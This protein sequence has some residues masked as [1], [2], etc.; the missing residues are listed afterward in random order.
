MCQIAK[1]LSNVVANVYDGETYAITYPFGPYVH[2]G[3]GADVKHGYNPGNSTCYYDTTVPAYRPDWC[4]GYWGFSEVRCDEHYSITALS[5]YGNSWTTTAKIPTALGVLTNL[6]EITLDTMGLTGP[7]PSQL[8][9]L[10]R[11]TTLSLHNN[12]LTGSVPAFVANVSSWSRVSLNNNCN[13]TSSIPAISNQMTFSSQGSCRND[14]EVIAAEGQAICKIARAWSNVRISQWNGN[15]YVPKPVFSNNYGG[16]TTQR[17]GYNPANSTCY[18]NTSMP[19]HQPVWCSFWSG[20]SCSNNKVTSLSI[21]GNSWTN[22][23]KVPTAIGALT[24]L[25]MLSLYNMGLTGSIPNL[26]GLSRLSTLQLVRNMLTGVVPKF[27]NY[28]ANNN[29]IQLDSNCNLTSPN[30]RIAVRLTNNQGGQYCKPDIAAIAAEGQAMCAVAQAWSN[31]Q[32]SR[33]TGHNFT[34][35][36]VFGSFD[37]ASTG[38]KRTGYIP[39]KTTCNYYTNGTHNSPSSYQPTWCSWIGV[40]CSNNR[41]SQLNPPTISWTKTSKIPTALGALGNLQYLRFINAG[42]S[43]S[44]PNL[45]GLSKLQSLYLWGNRLTGDVPAFINTMTT[46]PN[47]YIDLEPNCN[48]TWTSTSPMGANSNAYYQ[49]Q[50]NCAPLVPLKPGQLHPLCRL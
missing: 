50:G 39:G 22:T 36:N 19:L 44:I 4:A 32:V 28:T 42:L 40:T 34:M 31:M 41:V 49:S 13:L 14:R 15:A 7:I 48:L 21:T 45:V 12:M 2:H 37:S 3:G 43:G 47:T 25:Q 23:A 24:N 33:Y 38:L 9:G 8:G 35:T 16:D 5:V 17:Y 11:L 30:P 20:I 18:Y 29:N 46:R 10:S 27:V 26:M 1:A 6:Q